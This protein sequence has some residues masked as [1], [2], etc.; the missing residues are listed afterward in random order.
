MAPFGCGC[1]PLCDDCVTE[2]LSWFGGVAI[3]HGEDWSRAVANILPIDRPWPRTAKSREIA[4]RKAARLTS[5]PRLLEL[6]ADRIELGAE[7]WWNAALA[8]K[9]DAG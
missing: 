8:V 3:N 5:D 6:L 1:S 7:Q 4:L 9:R 2:H